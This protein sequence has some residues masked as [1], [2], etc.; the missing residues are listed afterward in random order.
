MDPVLWHPAPVHYAVNTAFCAV[1]NAVA[2][3]PR[4][5]F[6]HGHPRLSGAMARFSGWLR[7]L[8]PPLT[9]RR[10]GTLSLRPC[11]SLLLLLRPFRRRDNFI[12]GPPAATAAFV[13]EA[14]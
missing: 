3:L 12:P 11:H 2:M 10:C 7:L 4:P 8:F 5:Q 13:F 14:A 1:S 6:C 9:A